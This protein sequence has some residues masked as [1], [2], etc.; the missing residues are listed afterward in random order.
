VDK[1]ERFSQEQRASISTALDRFYNSCKMPWDE[2]MCYK[3]L[4]SAGL[5]HEEA[6]EIIAE[7]FDA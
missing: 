4:I 2:G 1:G 7:A 5:T 3:L 6:V